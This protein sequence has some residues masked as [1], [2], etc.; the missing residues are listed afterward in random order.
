[1]FMLQ[2]LTHLYDLV[3]PPRDSELIIRNHKDL[4]SIQPSRTDNII[5][6]ADFHKP[7]IHASV[8]ENKYF[9]N[10]KAPKILG[11]LLAQWNESQTKDILYV[12]V[13][14]GPERLKKRGYNQVENILKA[15][16]L[17]YKNILLR[18]RDTPPQTDLTRSQRLKN[19]ENAFEV[20]SIDLTPYDQIVIVDDV[21]TTGTTLQTTAAVLRAACPNE[22]QIK[23]LAIAH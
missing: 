16:N 6:L 14:L 11:Q 19:L 7:I 10:R 18:T 15:S 3:Y 12:P 8:V 2:L 17:P 9:N 4:L 23:L 20:K 1:M 22:T 21:T 5:Y 13:P